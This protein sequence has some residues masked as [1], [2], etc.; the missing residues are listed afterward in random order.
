VLWLAQSPRAAENQAAVLAL[1]ERQCERL[2]WKLARAQQRST[3]AAGSFLLGLI[4]T[5]MLV[6]RTS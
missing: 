2:A 6:L 5:P 4:Q 1:C 3:A